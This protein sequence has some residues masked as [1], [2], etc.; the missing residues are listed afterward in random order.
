MAEP[1]YRSDTTHSSSRMNALEL[2]DGLEGMGGGDDE[3]DA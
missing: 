1:H 3:P 2:A